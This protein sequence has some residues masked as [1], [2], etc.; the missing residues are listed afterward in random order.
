MST[1][2]DKSGFNPDKKLKIVG[3]SPVKHDGIDKV[4]GRAKFGADLFLPGMLIGKILRSPHPHAIIRSIDTTAAESLP[5][6]KAVV[7]RVDFPELPKGSVAGDMSR[8]AMAREKALYDGHPVAAVAATSESIAKQALKLIKVDYEALPHVI[9]PI[10]AM[11]PAAPILHDHIRT[12]GVKDA[13]EKKT[14]VVERLE[15]KMGDVEA[16]FAQADVIV[17]H[18]YDTKPMHQG[19]IEPQGC[20][21]TC[22]EDGQV[23]L[24]CCTQGP[25]VFRDRLTEILKIESSKIRVTQS[26]LGGGFGGKTGFYAEPI[27]VL[28]ARKSKR[29]VKIVLTRGEVFRGTGPV[30]GTRSRIKMGVTRDGKITAADADLVFQTGAFTGSMFFNAPQAM[31]T[32]YDL[33]NVKTVSYEVVSN[34]PKVNSFRAPCVPQVVFGVEGVVNELAQKIGMDPL[35]LRI[36]NA[37]TEGYKTIYGE[38]FGPIGFL[39]TL[40][41]AKNCDHYKSPVPKGQGR[42]VAAGFWFNR[43]G[44]T[45]GTL[46]IATDGSVTI[47]LGTTDVAGSRISISMMAAE[48]LGIPVDKVRA[49]MADTHALGWNRITAGSRT[50]YSSGM[51]IIDSARKAITE[52]CR[53]AALIWGV[54]EEGVVFEDG[55]CRPASSNV[56][57]FPPLSIAEIAGK[58]TLTLGAIA[59]HSE[60]NVTGAGPG[61]GVH[62]V[63]VDVDQELGRVDIKRYTVVEDAGKAIH[64]LQVEGQYQGGAVQGIG[65]ALNEEYVYGEDGRLQNPSFLDYRMPVASD[66]PMIDTEIVEVP[67]PR[68]PYGLRG[69]GEVPVTPTM[70]AIA[71]AIGAVIGVRPRSLPMSPPKILKLIEEARAA[72]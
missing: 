69:V 54:P 47:I 31:F 56:G 42:G 53:R 63:D 65:W 68:H 67:N 72:R 71:N 51:V 41:A 20:V 12:K 6:V 7:T 5:G 60:M 59:G 44:E 45:T 26:E 49:V 39:E 55:Y 37:A 1:I 8:N 36:K 66:V 11:K 38:T 30:S 61:F 10:D 52:V 22:T 40:I 34:R 57:E 35:D 17:E 62:I 24:W 3:S 48:E 23:E 46:N 18:E 70:A 21:A 4:T 43:G 58:T 15:L 16:G 9:D 28:L 29:P 32:R 2:L 27:A 13:A 50:T 25:W 19:Y 14:N 33:K 64:R